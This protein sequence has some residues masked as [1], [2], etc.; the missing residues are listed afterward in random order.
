M[1]SVAHFDGSQIAAAFAKGGTLFVASEYQVIAA[2]RED[3]GKAESHAAD[4]DIFFV[5]EGSATF[6]TGGALV[7]SHE[8]APGEARAA[9]GIAGGET[10]RLT[11]GEVMVVPAGTPHWLKEVSNPFLYFVVKVR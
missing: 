4:T 11:R 3:P 5:V 1:A 8:I 2:R 10:W 7:E 9:G 6:V